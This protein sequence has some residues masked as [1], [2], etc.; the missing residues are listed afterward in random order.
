MRQGLPALDV[1]AIGAYLAGITA[2]GLWMAKRA[3]SLRD[4]FLGGRRFGKL[5]MVMYAFG[6]GTHT[7]HA[8]AVAGAAVKLGMAGIWYQWLWLFC[9]PF[10]WLIAP[11]FRRT[12]YVTIGDFYEGRYSKALAVV[13]ALWGILVTAVQMGLMLKGTGKVIE[14]TTGGAI[15]VG[16]AVALTTLL[17]V[18]YGVAGGIPA[19]VVTDL[20]QGSMIIILSFLI[21]PFML[22]KVGG[23]AGLHQRL[24]E[25]MFRLTAPKHPPPPYD[26]ITPFYIFMITLNALV[27]IVAQPHTLAVTSVGRT[28]LDG[29]VGFC[30]GNMVLSLI[31]I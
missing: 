28:E 10:Y 31:H 22:Q 15:T 6:T 2:L 8:V 18:I 24:S 12:R 29:R 20:I 19:A 16:W 1:F 9:T 14:A 11:W 27:G 21:L 4:Y 7:D 30:Y 25:E 23:F 26:P 17:F 3:K 5:F 13:Y